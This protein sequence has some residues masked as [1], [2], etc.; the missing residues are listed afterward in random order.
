MP[1]EQAHG[2]LE[3]GAD[4]Q[5][6]KLAELAPV[7]GVVQGDSILGSAEGYE[8][9]AES[10]GADVD[11]PEIATDKRRFEEALEKFKDAVTAKPGLT[12]AAMSPADDLVYVANPEGFPIPGESELVERRQVPARPGPVG[13]PV[14]H[15]HGQ[16]GVG[17]EA[18]QMEWTEGLDRVSLNLVRRRSQ[19]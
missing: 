3:E 6:K 2:G 18:D 16:P 9:L 11:D 4:E 5:S 12:A 14:V 15:A 13:R 1:V 8:D 7:V 17:C 10:L 19:R